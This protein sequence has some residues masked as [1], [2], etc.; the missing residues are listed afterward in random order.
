M[1]AL[2]AQTGLVFLTYRA[3]ST[4]DE[5]V[6]RACAGDALFDFEASDGVRHTVWAVPPGDVR[7]L[8]T[9]FEVVPALY[10]ADGHHRAASA[11][12]ARTT[13]TRG[14]EAIQA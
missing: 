7:A 8:A 9:A 2:R 11:A 3:T 12:R 6:D 10:I 13:I 1:L 4:I 5:A 14:S